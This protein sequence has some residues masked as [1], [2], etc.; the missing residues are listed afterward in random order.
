MKVRPSTDL[1]AGA[2]FI[3]VGA[4][5]MVYGS[6]YA[7]GTASRMGA[8]YFPRLISSGLVLIGLVLVLRAIVFARGEVMGAI[9]WRPLLLILA[10]VAAFGLLIDRVGLL[11]AGILLIVAARLAD[12]EWAIVET[13]LLALGL[14]L[15]TAALFLWG[16]GLP[17]R[18]LRY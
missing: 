2:L 17:I 14:T 12:R 5:A 11:P 15:G 18:L 7:V 16:L 3:A 1:V 10:G 13:A 9:G 6:R 8:G 4:F